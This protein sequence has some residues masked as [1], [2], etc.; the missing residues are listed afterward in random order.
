M[1]VDAAY[2]FL[3]IAPPDRGEKPETPPRHYRDASA[4]LPRRF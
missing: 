4:T 1:T 2:E 3:G